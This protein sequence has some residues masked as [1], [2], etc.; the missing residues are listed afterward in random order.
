MAQIE[1]FGVGC[2][3]KLKEIL[4]L[5]KV[6]CFFLVTGDN[7]FVKSGADRV[8]ESLHINYE[9]FTSFSSNPKLE[10]LE[11][12]LENF[13]KKKF[14]LIVAIGGGSAIDTA[15]AIKQ[16]YFEK[17]NIKVPLVAIPTVAGS[18]SEA[19]YFIVYYQNGLKQ[20][21]GLPEL[22]LPNYVIL[23][24]S[25]IRQVPSD[26]VASAGIDAFSQAIESFWSVNS[27]EESKG[28]SKRA[29]QLLL[30]NLKNSIRGDPVANE[31]VLIASNL[32][33]KA[34]NLAKTT[35]CHAIA[36]PL[37]SNFKIR[38]GQAVSLTLGEMLIF[39]SKIKSNCCI[40]P[41]GVEYVIKTIDEIVHLFGTKFPE[42]AKLKI[43]DF[44]VSIGLK[45]RLSDFGINRNQVDEIISM[46]SNPERMKN[47]PR[48]V[49]NQ[50]LKRILLNIF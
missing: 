17:T 32:A 45:T 6:D 48:L 49:T 15:K 28:Y 27:T 14:D 37:T 23:D 43:E 42:E 13:L 46:I 38:H 1:F 21:W 30:H 50:D 36:Y 10:E 2:L 33:G 35:A 4:N 40:D 41:R 39:N 8:I 18:G 3:G 24:P 16:L 22:T 29:I 26:I 47:N 5:E 19:T 31:S 11:L 7:S 44:I 25:L 9:K 20:S 34:I 12:G